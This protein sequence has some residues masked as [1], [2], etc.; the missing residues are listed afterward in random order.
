MT[1]QPHIP[2]CPEIFPEDFFKEDFDK[3]I[4]LMPTDSE[5]QIQSKEH[6]IGISKQIASLPKNQEKIDTLKIYLDEIDRRRN[7]NWR[8]FFPWLIEQ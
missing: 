2:L 4:N 7:K 5:F 1:V 3:I 8:E 6:M